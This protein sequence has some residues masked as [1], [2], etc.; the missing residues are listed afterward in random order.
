MTI[1]VFKNLGMGSRLVYEALGR[2]FDEP[3]QECSVWNYSTYY[4]T[5]TPDYKLTRKEALSIV[6]PHIFVGDD[7]ICVQP[8]KAPGFEIEIKRIEGFA[9]MLRGKLER[10]Q[11]IKLAHIIRQK[12]AKL[13]AKND[14]LQLSIYDCIADNEKSF[15]LYIKEMNFCDDFIERHVVYPTQFA[16]GTSFRALAV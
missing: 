5:K 7:P 10:E 8:R 12:R 6:C 9:G 4:G 3:V 15:E 16:A 11:L 14:I 1:Y 13:K 2:L